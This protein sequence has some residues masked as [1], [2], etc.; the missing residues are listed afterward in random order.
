[1]QRSLTSNSPNNIV[2]AD[3]TETGTTRRPSDFL[4]CA[5]SRSI[6]TNSPSCPGAGGKAC[7][8]RRSLLVPAIGTETTLFG[9]L[10]GLMQQDLTRLLAS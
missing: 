2:P 1:M 7:S 3:D 4:Y 10:Y 6:Q 8:Y 9:L 5:R